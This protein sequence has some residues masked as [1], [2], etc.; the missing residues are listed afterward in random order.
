MPHENKW[1]EDETIPYV[2]CKTTCAEIALDD[3]TIEARN[4]S[5]Y[6]QIKV[7]CLI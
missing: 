1:Y 6:V 5:A 7:S 3:I 2:P 4:T